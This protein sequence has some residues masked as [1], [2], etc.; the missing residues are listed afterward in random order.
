MGF[1]ITKEPKKN[2]AACKACV[3][4]FGADAVH[5]VMAY[6]AWL[7]REKKA[8]ERPHWFQY[9]TSYL[10]IRQFWDS[11]QASMTSDTWEEAPRRAEAAQFFNR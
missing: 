7:K 6:L 8:R 11:I 4:D 1:R 3:A 2:E 5:R 10:K 9:V